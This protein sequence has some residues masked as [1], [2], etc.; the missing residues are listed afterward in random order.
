MGL[1]IAKN[2]LNPSNNFLSTVISGSKGDWFNISQITGLL[3]QQNLLGQRVSP[4]LNNG[5]RTLPHYQFE[6]LSLKEEYESRG[7]I[8][9]SFI[10]GLNPKQY[11]VHCMSGREGCC[12]KM[13]CHKQVA[14]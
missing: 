5:K 9:S 1:R 8:D 12:D 13:L 2:A 14:A 6:N 3:G 4:V 11:Y 10:H 7:F